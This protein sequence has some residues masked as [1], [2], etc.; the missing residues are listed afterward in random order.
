MLIQDAPVL[1]DSE[2]LLIA[3]SDADV[4]ADSEAIY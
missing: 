4:F 1:A 2:I 3:D